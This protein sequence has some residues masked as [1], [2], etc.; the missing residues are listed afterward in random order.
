[1][2]IMPCVCS[3]AMFEAWFGNGWL[4]GLVGFVLWVCVWLEEIK[5]KRFMTRRLEDSMSL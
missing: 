1:M 3:C 2:C 4:H 5:G